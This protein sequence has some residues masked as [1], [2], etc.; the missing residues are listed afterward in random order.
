[1]TELCDHQQVGFANFMDVITARDFPCLGARSAAATKSLSSSE[2]KSLLDTNS[3]RQVIGELELFTATVKADQT[4][5]HSFVA[6]YPETPVLTESAF[7]TAIWGRLTAL[8]AC[9]VALNIPAAENVEN[10]PTHPSFAL[11]F[12]GMGMFIVGVH[13]NASRPARRFPCAAIIFN[14]HDQFERLRT[15]GVYEKMRAKILDRDLIFAGS[16]NPMIARYGEK[17]EAAQYSG[18]QVS[19]AWECPFA[20]RDTLTRSLSSTLPDAIRNF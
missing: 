6:L 5:L 2:G 20:G 8:Q 18:R 4:R 13:P 15:T 11:S 9:E 19:D 7:E 3:D 1:M 10:D 17:S 12:G 14:P 16:Q